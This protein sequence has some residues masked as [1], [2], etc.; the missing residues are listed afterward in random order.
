MDL[1]NLPIETWRQIAELMQDGLQEVERPAEEQER[2]AALF[3]EV[4]NA[5]N[6]L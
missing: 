4:I 1:Y 5:I 2:L 3:H 6:E